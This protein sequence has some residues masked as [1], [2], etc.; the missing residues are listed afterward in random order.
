MYES[1]VVH[2]V[3]YFSQLSINWNTLSILVT[4]LKGTENLYLI[5]WTSEQYCH[6]WRKRSENNTSVTRDKCAGRAR[7]AGARCLHAPWPRPPHA[8]QNVTEPTHTYTLHVK[9]VILCTLTQKC[10]R[11][12]RLTLFEAF[13]TVLKKY[14]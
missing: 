7:G 14:L 6:L 4:K 2:Y 12:Y 13:S 5:N 8:A 9:H 11:S 10:S 3:N 1:S